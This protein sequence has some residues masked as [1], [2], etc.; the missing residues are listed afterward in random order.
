MSCPPVSWSCWCG[1][2]PDFYYQ[3]PLPFFWAG[4]IGIIDHDRVEISNLQRQI[5]H[6]EETL[7][8]YKAE[9]AAISLKRS[10]ILCPPSIVI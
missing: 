2:V 8:M 9:S 1:Y 4:K 10:A 6:T 3:E 7:G 5:L